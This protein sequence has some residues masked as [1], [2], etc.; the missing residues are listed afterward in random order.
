MYRILSLDLSTDSDVFY[1]ERS[2][3]KGSP[4]RNNTPAVLISTELSGAMAKE[5]ITISSV[6]L[7]EP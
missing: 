4:I 1:V 2:S 7:P 3:A 5:M 6:A